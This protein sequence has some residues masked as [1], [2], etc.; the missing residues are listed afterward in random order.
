MSHKQVVGQPIF[1]G[2]PVLARDSIVIRINNGA[3]QKSMQLG[4][5]YLNN[6]GVII[7]INQTLVVLAITDNQQFIIPLAPGQL[8]SIQLSLSSGTLDFGQMWAEIFLAFG[9]GSSTQRYQSI[10][11]GYPGTNYALSW[12]STNNPPPGSGA[13]FDLTLTPADPAAGAEFDVFT[14]AGRRMNIALLS[15]TFVTNANAANRS[16]QL[17]VLDASSNQLLSLGVDIVQAASITR[18]YSFGVGLA[19]FS[20]A[21]D[22][23][24]TAPIPPLI[25]QGS[26]EFISQTVNRQAG[27]QFQDIFIQGTEWHGF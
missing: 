20:D 7:D 11:S 9:T 3:A 14:N 10:L 8:L 22:Q 16:V 26:W 12:P 15:F 2:A 5:R 6:D 4:A 19:Q 13:G 1:D 18:H 24:V 27:D 25:T 23:I 17:L 21:V